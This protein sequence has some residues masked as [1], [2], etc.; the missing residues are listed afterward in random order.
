MFW[1]WASRTVE[2]LL[3]APVASSAPP[4]G[5]SRPVGGESGHCSV[6]SPAPAARAVRQRHHQPGALSEE[7]EPLPR[8]DGRPRRDARRGPRFVVALSAFRMYDTHSGSGRGPLADDLR[9][10]TTAARRRDLQARGTASRV[11]SCGRVRTWWE[12]GSDGTDH[13]AAGIGLL[14]GTRVRGNMIGEFPA[15]TASTPTAT[16]GDRRLSEHL[17]LGAR[18]VALDRRERRHPQRQI[19]RT[20]AAPAMKGLAVVVAGFAFA[21][22]LRAG[23]GPAVT[24]PGRR[25]RV[26]A[27]LV[28]IPPT[29]ANRARE[30][31]AGRA[32]PPPQAD[33]R[34][35]GLPPAVGA[36]GTAADVERA[37]RARPL[38]PQVHPRRPRCARD[39][40]EAQG[41]SSATTASLNR[42]QGL[43]RPVAEVE[44]GEDSERELAI[45]ID[46]EVA[47]APVSERSRRREGARWYWP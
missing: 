31:R 33:R 44:I 23:G 46:E 3:Q 43:L 18:A 37:P 27:T 8:P 21:G 25:V 2:E 6:P 40:L 34:L 29:R 22:A 4:A 39:A 1:A 9:L 38:S 36:A 15:W 35:E 45:R 12:N 24:R 16:E 11:G 19:V 28:G 30:L 42:G 5:G 7:R 32:R 26:P 41:R 17:L 13:G 47:A 20:G 10:T 14:M